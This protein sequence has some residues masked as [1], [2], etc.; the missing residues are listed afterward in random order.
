[1]NKRQFFIDYLKSA[2]IEIPR[3]TG[4]DTGGLDF[5]DQPDNWENATPAETVVIKN[6]AVALSK[7]TEIVPG[8]KFSDSVRKM[9]ENDP[10]VAYISEIISGEHEYVQGDLLSR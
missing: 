2:Q 10:D 7:K 4:T 8:E 3:F 6:R 5:L 9:A 1:M